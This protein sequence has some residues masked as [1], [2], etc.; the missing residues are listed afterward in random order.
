MPRGISIDSLVLQSPWGNNAYSSPFAYQDE[1]KRNERIRTHL[2]ELLKNE[3]RGESLQVL[4]STLFFQVGTTLGEFFSSQRK[5]D[6][7]STLLEQRITNPEVFPKY[8]MLKTPISDI[9]DE[10][11]DT[12]ISIWN[13]LEVPACELR[14]LENFEKFK[15]EKKATIFLG[16]LLNSKT[17]FNAAT[18]QAVVSAIYKNIS[19]FSDD[20]GGGLFDSEFDRAEKLLIHLI[21]ESIPVNAIEELFKKIVQETPSF[22]FATLVIASCARARKSHLDNIVERVNVVVLKQNLSA[23]FCQFFIEEKRDIFEV[24]SESSI[25]ILAQWGDFSQEDKERVNDYVFILIENNT[26]YIGKIIKGYTQF[27]EQISYDNLIKLYD[28]NKLYEK[29]KASAED[30]FSDVAEEKA[31]DLF[32]QVYEEKR[33]SLGS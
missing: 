5:S 10:T 18:T 26:R 6:S 14:F 30:S 23:R 24:E 7:K 29:I 20:R 4:L 16:K 17:L 19:C 2:L 22:K 13:R 28:E 9:P 15:E 31:I 12:I 21:N 33:T 11:I 32:V 25:Y 27:G 8:F 3:S 1:E